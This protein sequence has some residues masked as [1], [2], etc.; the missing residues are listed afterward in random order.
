MPVTVS[1]AAEAI[2][3]SINSAIKLSNNIRRA[4]A[5]S[6]RGKELVLPLPDFDRTLNLTQVIPFIEAHLSSL[7]PEEKNR[8][9]RLVALQAKATGPHSLEPEEREEYLGYYFFLK[10]LKDGK[11]GGLEMD[12]SELSALFTIRQWE[13]GKAPGSVLQLVA[14]SLVEIGIDYF[15]QVPGALNPESVQGRLIQSF[16]SAFDGIK[17]ADNPHIKKDF[18]T[19]LVPRLFAS[20]AES[21]STL[22][23]EVANDEKVQALI[24]ATAKGIAEDL[25][26]RAEG[27]DPDE[28][29]HWGQLILRSTI[30]HAGHFVLKSPQ[31]VFGT[32]DGVSKIIESSGLVLLDA[33]LG[34]DPDKIDFK[35]ALNPASLDR[36]VG[37]TLG[38]IADH[39]DMINGNRGVREIIT[40]VAKAMQDQSILEK[41]Y[42]P[43]L[44]RIVLEQSAG[45]LDLLWRELPDGHGA[46]HVLVLAISQTLR[47]LSE[48]QDGDVWRPTITNNQLLGILEE[49]LDD[50]AQNPAWVIG[51]VG[52]HSDLAKVLEA[53]FSA[54]RTVSKDERLN[55]AMV[56]RIIR[57]NIELTLLSPKVLDKIQWGTDAEE[58]AILTKALDLVFACAFD[59][60]V[61][62]IRRMQLLT[63]LLEY[64]ASVVLRQHPGKNGLVLLDIVLFK[65]GID[66]SQGFDQHLTDQL[67]DAALKAIASQPELVAKPELLQ[68]VLSG[69][70]AALDHAKLKQPGL[71][72]RLV[73]LVLY[74][75][76]QN[77]HL[78]LD[79]DQD[80]PKHLLVTA[81][82]LILEGLSAT[83]GSGDW[84]PQ[85]GAAQVENLIETMLDEV[86]QHPFWINK[87]ADQDTLLGEVMHAVILALETIPKQERLLQ[88]NLEL[89]FRLSLRVAASSPHVLQKIQFA[90][91]AQEKEILLRALEL[92]FAYCFPEEGDKANRKRLLQEL[93]EFIMEELISKYPDKRSLILIDLVLFEHNGID[94]SL[95]FQPELARQLVNAALEVLSQQPELIIKDQTLRQI[96]A[97]VAATVH[98]SGLN[99]P[100]LLPELIQLALK[101]TAEHIDL[102]LSTTGP[103]NTRHLFVM[104]AMQV[105]NAIAQPTE[106]GK[107]KPQLSDDQ[108]IEIISLIYET[109]QK[110]PQWALQDMPLFKVMEAVFLALQRVPEPYTIPYSLILIMIEEAILAVGK[111]WEF[112]VKIQSPGAGSQLRLQV[113]LDQLVIALYQENGDARTAWYLSQG[114]IVKLLIHYYLM[115][116]AQTSVNE[117]DIKAVQDQL[118]NAIEAW[119]GDFNQ[120]LSEILSRI[121]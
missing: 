77:A 63:D 52:E 39:P 66:Y 91:D 23:T 112:L 54:F 64:T 31:S 19:K 8:A 85:F 29:V 17:L 49:L 33:I 21:L 80:Q 69:V 2:I 115:Q 41:G 16:L 61:P 113:S 76:G 103:V 120:D 75:T 74:H 72:T 109:I 44:A 110:N 106:D 104:A 34:D 84:K 92:V 10:E 11:G 83:D 99:Q 81:L 40:G 101:S 93:I 25:F 108:I 7:S 27:L 14:G 15:K 24:Q 65:S 50:V 121:D 86:V 6:I 67:I 87:M 28:A 20:A 117:Q 57:M 13:R 88:K 48:K 5:L 79:A 45:K 35:N 102:L 32:N 119:K 51:A 70:A 60:E 18:S 1:L 4:Y 97:N 30:N 68:H 36:L 37:A 47:A 111:Q 59:K 9:E 105:L 26:K 90:D 12:T 100:G 89:L 95:G 62:P 107:W 96:I 116:L 22:S 42:L 43:E 71:A 94:Y 118:R 58:S 82:K 3:F 55:P 38:V 114:H 78:L 56:R 98:A 53:T 46:E 73:Q